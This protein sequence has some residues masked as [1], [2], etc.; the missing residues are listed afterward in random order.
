MKKV[1]A[2]ALVL[3][4]V[5]S[6]SVGAFAEGKKIAFLVSDLAETFH[7]ASYEA[8]KEF[9]A[10]K[11]DEVIVFDG[12][13]EAADQIKMLDQFLAQGIDMATM[14][15]WENEAALPALNDLLDNGVVC[16]SFFGPIVGSGIPAVRNDE[17][18]VSY[19]MG[20]EMATAWKEAN[21]DTPI[22]MV[23]LGWPNH[24]QVRS[25]RTDPFVEGVL[26]VDPEAKDLGCKE[27][28]NADEGKSVLAGIL[29]A[30]PEV[31]L[32]YAESGG[33]CKGVLSALEDAARGTTATE[34]VCTCDFDDTQFFQIYGDSS[35]VCSLGLSPKETGKA[36]VEYLY[37]I[38]DGEI[39]Q[40]SDVEEEV[41]CGATTIS[42]YS[43]T[44]EETAQ[45]LAD[46]WGIDVE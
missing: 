20:V 16:A 3:V 17:A 26:S 25:G 19:Q 9:A 7:Q 22:V 33:I 1:F 10:E 15:V 45:W 8:G 29:S 11:G 37:K 28:N 13:G 24:E 32:I 35:L 41:F 30:N 12:A 21:P 18:G 38:A 4:M 44:R 40:V 6:L 23:E 46:E 27:A 5:I 14:H 31:N 39:A 43:M 34:L 36:R 42:V 2:L